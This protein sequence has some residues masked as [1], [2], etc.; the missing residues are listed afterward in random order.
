MTLEVIL[1]GSLKLRGK[2]ILNIG[3]VSF[4]IKDKLNLSKA[5]NEEQ[6]LIA[7]IAEE[8]FIQS[9]NSLRRKRNKNYAKNVT[10]RCVLGI[11]REYA[12]RVLKNWT[13]L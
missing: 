9:T 3:S 13:P 1:P 11:E 10:S 12:T 6:D 7:D 4:V 8:L 5:G 2:G